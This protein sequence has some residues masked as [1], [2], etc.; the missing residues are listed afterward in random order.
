VIRAVAFD[1][2]DTLYAESEFVLS[3]YRAVADFVSR[4]LGVE[5]YAA[6]ADRFKAGLRADPFTPVLQAATGS[7][8]EAYVQHLVS[9]YRTHQPQVV[10]YPETIAVLERLRSSRRIGLITDGFPGVQERKLEALGIRGLFDA[11]VFTSVWGREFWKPHP[12]GY[13]ECATAL[14]I[15]LESMAY[16]GDNPAK[17]FVMARQ[18]GMLTIRVRRAGILHGAVDPLPGC[19]PDY[20]AADLNEAADL[21]L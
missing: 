19:E 21:L 7:V 9:I 1:L 2:D 13:E 8:E 17:D 14:G 5:I 20:E 4:D 18:L 6:L 12:R 3:G 11:T 16:V 10:P 15:P